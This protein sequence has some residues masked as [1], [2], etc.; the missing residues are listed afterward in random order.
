MRMH[1]HIYLLLTKKID[2][3]SEFNERKKEKSVGSISKLCESDFM[4]LPSI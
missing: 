1:S 4:L 3:K 2:L